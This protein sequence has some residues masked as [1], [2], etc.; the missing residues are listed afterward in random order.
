MQTGARGAQLQR[1]CGIC[2]LS[3]GDQGVTGNAVSRRGRQCGLRFKITWQIYAER[4]TQGKNG[5][6]NTWNPNVVSWLGGQ[7]SGSG[8]AV[9]EGFSFQI[10]DIFWRE[11]Q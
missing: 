10:H 1:P 11:S 2:A 8:Q 9:S 6:I 7:R 5:R 4:I 3:Y